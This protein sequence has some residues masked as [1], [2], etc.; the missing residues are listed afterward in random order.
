MLRI[1]RSARPALTR[2]AGVRNARFDH[3]WVRVGQRLPR[4]NRVQPKL[5]VLVPRILRYGRTGRCVRGRRRGGWCWGYVLLSLRESRFALQN[6]W[7]G[8]RGGRRKRERAA[9]GDDD[10]DEV[11]GRGRRDGRRRGVDSGDALS[12]VVAVTPRWGHARDRLSGG[13][14]VTNHGRVV[15]GGSH[16]AS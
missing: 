15:G 10:G 9:A 2:E 14:V 3:V 12:S 4:A 8:G 5:G 1:S 11:P 7:R 6:A 13:P 16:F